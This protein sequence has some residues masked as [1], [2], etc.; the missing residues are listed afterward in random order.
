MSLYNDLDLL[1]TRQ[2]LT[3]PPCRWLMD[4]LIPEEGFVALYGNPSSGKS[5]IALDWAMCIS[6]GRS[7]LGRYATK[8]NPV[9]YVA[10]EGGRGIQRRVRAWMQHYGYQ[11]LPAMYY[12]LNPLYI[13][14]EGT[15]EAFLDELNQKDIWPGLIVLDT[16]SRSFGGGDEN[17]PTDMGNFVDKMTILAKGRRMAALVIHH[18]NASGARERGHTAFRGGLDTM[19]RCSVERDD[20]R[21]IARIEVANDKQKDDAEIPPI[22][23]API[24]TVTT[25]LVFQLADPPEKP[26]RGDISLRPM[27]AVDTLTALRT[28]EDGLT[29]KEWRIAT[30]LSKDAFN[31]RL[32]RLLKDGDIYKEDGRYYLTPD[33]KDLAALGVEGDTKS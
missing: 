29:W 15:V 21:Q 27:R 17:A 5:F 11:D 8:Q 6:E 30:N 18:Q 26:K 32:R 23:I 9:V 2:L 20:Q 33:E 13:R 12:L 22:Y 31:A 7:W 4:S 14:Q 10:A 19:F 3:L 24:P 16:L 25:S 28:A 1:T